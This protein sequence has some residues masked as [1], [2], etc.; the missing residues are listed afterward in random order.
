MSLRDEIREAF[1]ELEEFDDPAL[2]EGVERAW[3]IALEE[4]GRPDLATYPW[5]MPYQAKLGL[6]DELLVP[7]TRE[8]TA[9]ALALAESLIETRG[10]DIDTDLIRAG[11]L[12]HDVSHLR[13]FDGEEW[14]RAG[15][16]LGHPYHGQYVARRAELPVEVEHMVLS[17]TVLTNVEPAF[18]EA[19]LLRDVDLAVA[20]S[21]RSRTVDDLRDAPDAGPH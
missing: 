2:A 20:N 11:G 15:D 17:H 5:F 21:I 9:A 1:P 3:E 10:M 18:I 13:E 14:T 12:V 4:A 6:G 19:E 16:L 8:V 7:H